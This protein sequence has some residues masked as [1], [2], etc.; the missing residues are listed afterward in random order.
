MWVLR[1]VWR[2]GNKWYLKNVTFT[3][4]WQYW[5]L[6][7]PEILQFSHLNLKRWRLPPVALSCLHGTTM[8]ISCLGLRAV[9]GELG[10]CSFLR[11][12]FTCLLLLTVLL[13]EGRGI[14][15]LR[16]LLCTSRYS[17]QS[18]WRGSYWENVLYGVASLVL[19]EYPT[20]PAGICCWKWP[21]GN[22]KQQILSPNREGERAIW[23]ALRKHLLVVRQVL[24][25]GLRQAD[26]SAVAPVGC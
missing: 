4:H 17:G 5:N 1:V 18:R 6:S 21:E 9:Y 15:E 2:S 23:L 11:D 8:V 3:S 20:I 25:P 10:S 14:S 16:E 24:L 7:V 26:G 13:L 22:V 19:L 12:L